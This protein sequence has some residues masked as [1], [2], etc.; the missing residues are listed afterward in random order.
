MQAAQTPQPEGKS[1]PPISNTIVKAIAEAEA[2][3]PTDLDTR[4]YDVID[5]EALNE[6]F[7]RDDGPAT[8]GCVSFKYDGYT[9]TVH[10]DYSVDIDDNNP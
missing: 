5:P 10:S 6:L 9:V 3:D 7:H 1:E 8:D 2:T 4:L